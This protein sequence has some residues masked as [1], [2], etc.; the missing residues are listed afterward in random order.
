MLLLCGV[1]A[2]P[3]SPCSRR[4]PLSTHLEVGEVASLL[5]TLAF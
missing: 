4:H 1:L 5:F 2:L 3:C